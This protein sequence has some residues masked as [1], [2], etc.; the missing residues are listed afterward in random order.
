[1]TMHVNE[2]H[3]PQSAVNFIIILCAHFCTIVLNAAFFYLHGIREKLPKRLLY[4]KG[5]CKMLMKLTP[6]RFFDPV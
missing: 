6:E 1:M 3:N 4:K 2:L 5:T